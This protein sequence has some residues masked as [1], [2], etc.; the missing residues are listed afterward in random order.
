MAENI[1][2][3]SPGVVVEMTTELSPQPD[4]VDSPLLFGSRSRYGSCEGESSSLSV[5]RCR[6]DGA[7][8]AWLLAKS[9]RLGP[10]ENLD[11]SRELA[12]DASENLE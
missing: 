4:A 9:S 11:R 1:S 12:S 5:G 7:G 6:D 3:C 10:S 8:E 2:V